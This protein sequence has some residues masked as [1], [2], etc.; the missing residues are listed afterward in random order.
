MSQEE[1]EVGKRKFSDEEIA[2]LIGALQ[3][4]CGDMNSTIMELFGEDYSEDDLTEEERNT[5]DNQVFLCT[6][7]GWWCEA[8]QESQECLDGERICEECHEIR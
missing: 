6:D 1:K 3:G 8:C 2:D 5:I 7:C 4:T